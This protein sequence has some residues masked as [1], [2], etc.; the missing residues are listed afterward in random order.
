MV[1]I[2]IDAPGA[3]DW[4]MQRAD[5]YFREGW[6]HAFTSHDGERVLGGFA[7][8]GYLGSSL[9]IHMASEDPRWC[10]RELMWLVFHYAFEQLKCR[11]LLGAVR[12]DNYKA[13]ELNLRAGW[14]IEAVIEDVF[15][16]AHMLVISMTKDACRWLDYT[17]RS[18]RPA[19]AEAA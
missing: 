6:D 19:L 3:G 13:I 2:R 4:V 5:G 12:S 8:V 14:R 16:D 10:S 9:T 15:P 18:W 17:P 1:D 7:L 11:K